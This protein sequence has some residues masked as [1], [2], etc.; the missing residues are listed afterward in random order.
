MSIWVKSP[1]IT[2]LA[3]VDVPCVSSIGIDVVLSLGTRATISGM[4]IGLALPSFSLAKV[5]P[6]RGCQIIAEGSAALSN[7]VS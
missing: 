3:S 2:E 4:D 5:M 1:V 7:W 6:V